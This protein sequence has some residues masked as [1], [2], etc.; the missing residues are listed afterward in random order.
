M[1]ERIQL[2]G[3]A[4]LNEVFL[5]PEK[6]PANTLALLSLTLSAQGESAQACILASRAAPFGGC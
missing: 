6:R 2:Q 1:L 4:K 5:S 3:F